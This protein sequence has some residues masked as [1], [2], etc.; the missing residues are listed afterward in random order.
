MFGRVRGKWIIQAAVQLCQFQ[1]SFN[2]GK[3]SWGNFFDCSTLLCF[4]ISQDERHGGRFRSEKEF[5]KLSSVGFQ[6]GLL[7]MLWM[8]EWEFLIEFFWKFHGV[9]R[10]GREN[11]KHSIENFRNSTKS[12]LVRKVSQPTH[13]K[14]RLFCQPPPPP[15]FMLAR[16]FNRGF[17]LNYK[18]VKQTCSSTWVIYWLRIKNKLNFSAV[19]IILIKNITQPRL[20][21]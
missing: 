19:L 8:A 12:S 15:L 21:H 10:N 11:S 16:S 6:F 18:R 9:S 13:F 14:L 7:A 5:Q 1:I 17:K 3:A 20:I 4:V 2:G